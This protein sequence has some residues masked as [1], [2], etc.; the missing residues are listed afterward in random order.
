MTA[1][2][3]PEVQARLRTEQILTEPMTPADFTKF[4]EEEFL[5]WKPVAEQIG[6]KTN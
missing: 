1:F 5:R 2:A 6:L 3:K 4:V